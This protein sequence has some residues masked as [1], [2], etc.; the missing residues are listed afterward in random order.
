MKRLSL[1]YLSAYLLVNFIESD[2]FQ[3]LLSSSVVGELFNCH[4]CG[5]SQAWPRC[6]LSSHPFPLGSC[7]ASDSGEVSTLWPVAGTALGVIRMADARD[8][9]LRPRLGAVRCLPVSR[10]WISWYVE[11][12]LSSGP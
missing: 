10:H 11:E 8:L 9:G 1:R 5:L 3:I 6:C 2:V 7:V 12:E 4:S